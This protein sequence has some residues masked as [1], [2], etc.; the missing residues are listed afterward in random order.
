MKDWEAQDGEFRA[1]SATYA[2]V[3]SA[4]PL[5]ALPLF[6]LTATD[7]GAAPDLERQWQAWQAGYTALSTN[8][9]QQ[10]V[11]GATHESLVFSPTDSQATAEA[12]L[13]VIEAAHTGQ[14]LK[15]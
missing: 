10:I 13:Q 8:S 11:R 7:H 14:A 3:L 9:V 6:V 4:K 15:R 12:I 1:S 5:G 2:Q